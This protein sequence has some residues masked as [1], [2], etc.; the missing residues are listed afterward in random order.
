MPDVGPIKAFPLNLLVKL[1]ALLLGAVFL[2]ACGGGGPAATP[3][4][5]T[6]AATVEPT[7]TAAPPPTATVA[8]AATATTAPP[9]TAVPTNTPALAPT[10]TPVP[11]P[12]ATPTEPPA[13]A[14]LVLP[15]FED[16]AACLQDRLGADIAQAL[17]AGARQETAEEIAILEE[18]L[19]VRATGVAGGA[20]SPAAAACLEDSLGPSVVQIVAH[21]LVAMCSSYRRP[22]STG[23]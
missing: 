5:A 3:V 8:P 20:L 19:L 7:A 1:L 17:L 4:P 23:Q 12:T 21:A 22:M 13:P 18:C 11:T 10:A 15:G 6:A 16:V 14:A 9:P 2:A